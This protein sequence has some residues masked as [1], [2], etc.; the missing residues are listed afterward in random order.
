MKEKPY[1]MFSCGSDV[2]CRYQD[3]AGRSLCG[4]CEDLR[5]TPEE[6]V[7]RAFITAELAKFNGPDDRWWEG[8]TVCLRMVAGWWT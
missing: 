1:R 7:R 8:L 3:R 6:V 4:D 5:L 2:P